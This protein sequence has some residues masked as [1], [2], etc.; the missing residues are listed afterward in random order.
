MEDYKALKLYTTAQTPV[1]TLYGVDGFF[2]FEG[3]VFTVDV[4]LNPNKESPGAD[5]VLLLEDPGNQDELRE[6]TAILTSRFEEAI[7]R[8]QE[9][10]ARRQVA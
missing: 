10:A 1:D 9:E 5:F 7:E 2:E 4:T 8:Q 6:K 3:T